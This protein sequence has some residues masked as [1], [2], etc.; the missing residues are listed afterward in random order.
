MSNAEKFHAHLDACQ[1]CEQ[2]P[3][4]LCVVGAKLLKAAAEDAAYDFGFPEG[5]PHD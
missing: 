2:R 1:Q 3:F 5:S 4:E